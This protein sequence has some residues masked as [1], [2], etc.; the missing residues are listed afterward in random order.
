MVAPPGGGARI[1]EA[2]EEWFPVVWLASDEET[3]PDGVV[4]VVADR[5]RGYAVEP[6]DRYTE[7]A[8]GLPASSLSAHCATVAGNRREPSWESRLN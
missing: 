1:A 8:A 7:A 6:P 3:G 2:L 4:T 5:V